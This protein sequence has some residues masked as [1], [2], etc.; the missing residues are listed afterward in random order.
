MFSNRKLPK[1]Y[2]FEKYKYC[3]IN[4]L[5]TFIYSSNVSIKKILVDKPV[6]MIINNEH[7]QLKPESCFISDE[8]LNIY[9][10]E[11]IGE[12]GTNINILQVVLLIR[13]NGYTIQRFI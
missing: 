10:A 12:T 8:P 4:S 9:G 3:E 11:F 1:K 5:K 6:E 13:K 7:I 2:T